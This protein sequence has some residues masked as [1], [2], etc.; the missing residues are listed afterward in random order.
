MNSMV[1]VDVIHGHSS[2]V[3]L[4]MFSTADAMSSE[5]LN[6]CIHKVCTLLGTNTRQVCKAALGFVTVLFS[7]L[8]KPTL[9]Q[10]L[11]KIVSV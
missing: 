3:Y 10:H 5:L 7:I 2:F 6:D 1:C 8:T 9:A 4:M 11:D